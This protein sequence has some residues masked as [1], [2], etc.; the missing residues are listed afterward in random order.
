MLNAPS[1]KPWPN[2]STQLNANLQNQSLR[3]SF[4]SHYANSGAF[5]IN[6]SASGIARDTR[7]KRAPECPRGVQRTKKKKKWMNERKTKAKAENIFIK[8]YFCAHFILGNLWLMKAQLVH[9]SAGPYNG[10]AFYCKTVRNLRINHTVSTQRCRLSETQSKFNT[11]TT[12]ILAVHITCPWF[13]FYLVFL[14]TVSG[15]CYC[16]RT[17]LGYGSM[18]LT[19]FIHSFF[20]SK[21]NYT[22]PGESFL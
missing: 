21:H 17:I 18:C 3:G 20:H 1:F 2:K 12:L 22:Y 10:L 5:L 8:A 13:C 11:S 7:R 15:Q 4:A 19:P 16:S 9:R 6:Y 14:E